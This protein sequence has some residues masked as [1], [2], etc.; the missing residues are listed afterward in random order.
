MAVETGAS[1]VR[2][3]TTR[4]VT[5]KAGATRTGAARTGGRSARVTEAVHRSVL[6]LLAEGAPVTVPA[7]AARAGVNAT[8]VYRRWGDVPAL[9]TDTALARFGTR[10]APPATGTLRGDLLAW[11]TQLLAEASRPEELAL[12]R[13]AVAAG[14]ADPVAPGTADAV[15]GVADPVGT[16]CDACLTGRSDQAEAV[17]AAA[18]ER[19]ETPPTATRVLD[20]LVAPLYFRVLFGLPAAG[21]GI[22]E[23]LVDL[24]VDRLADPPGAPTGTTQA[25]SSPVG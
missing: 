5:T 10:A 19:G 1:G 22:V 20:H 9:L 8:S 11:G 18:R 4:A 16:A 14:P 12:L 17:V 7:V 23:R 25:P 15:P 24:L 6:A 3:A 13:A 21:T 2:G